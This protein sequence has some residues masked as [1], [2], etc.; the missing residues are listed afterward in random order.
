MSS[1]TQ[2]SSSDDTLHYSGS[3]SEDSH[4]HGRIVPP[5]VFMD[6]DDADT[7]AP[8][9]NMSRFLI[10]MDSL[11]T[12]RH[13]VSDHLQRLKPLDILNI[14]SLGSPAAVVVTDINQHYQ[15][16]TSRRVVPLFMENPKCDVIIEL[17]LRHLTQHLV[18]ATE[19][20]ASRSHSLAATAATTL[21]QTSA[22]VKPT[23]LTAQYC[24][25]NQTS[26]CVWRYN[27][28]FDELELVTLHFELPPDD[29][30]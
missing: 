13:R 11:K 27:E 21:V 3:D 6:A 26:L 24:S 19:S 28:S 16:Q 4:G 20:R 23:S 10:T 9:S 12:L 18:T 15:L 8:I 2:S 7:P 5:S 30:T 29:H 14:V 1:R 17:A 22:L 25:K